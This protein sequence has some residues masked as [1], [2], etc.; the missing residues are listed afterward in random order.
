M[1][2]IFIRDCRLILIA[3]ASGIAAAAAGAQSLEK[4]FA[5]KG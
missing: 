1:L 5:V 4:R 2:P 3:L